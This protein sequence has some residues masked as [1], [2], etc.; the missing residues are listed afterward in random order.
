MFQRPVVYRFRAPPFG[1]PRNDNSGFED[2]C[3]RV[4]GT[5]MHRSANQCLA[6]PYGI[7]FGPG[8][9]GTPQMSVAH[10][11]AARSQV[12]MMVSLPWVRGSPPTLH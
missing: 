3:M 8:T 12:G 4:C 1:R 2:I 9:G 7:G 11:N 5:L 6:L 10:G